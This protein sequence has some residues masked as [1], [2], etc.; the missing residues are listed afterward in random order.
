MEASVPQP[1]T[2]SIAWQQSNVLFIEQQASRKL[3]NS[4]HITEIYLGD[5]PQQRLLQLLQ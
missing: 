2:I 1:K 4:E 5:S 3:R